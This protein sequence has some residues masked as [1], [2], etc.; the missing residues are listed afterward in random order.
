MNSHSE[1]HAAHAPGAAHAHA[2]DAAHAED[3]FALYIKIFGGLCILTLA[4]FLS[5]EILN[6]A[7]GLATLS[8]FVILLIS[9]AKAALV[10]T[11]FM[12]LKWD[13]SKV[14]FLMVPVIIMGVMMIIV[15]LPDIVLGWHHLPTDA[16]T[17]AVEVIE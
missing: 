4:S 17:E 7:M 16:A 5:Y 15:L 14:Y 12:H 2:P 1:P 10:A 9:V 3:H 8:M 6:R 13:W 11:F